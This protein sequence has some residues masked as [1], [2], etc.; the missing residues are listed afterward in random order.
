MRSAV[1]ERKFREGKKEMSP[2]F[3]RSNW[4]WIV[5]IAVG[6][7][8]LCLLH[9]SRVSRAR[10]DMEGRLAEKDRIAQDLL[11]TML[12]N[13]QGLI[14]KIHAV[15]KQMAPEEPTRQALE[16]T[17]DRVDEVLAESSNQLR[18]LLGTDSHSDL[19]ADVSVLRKKLH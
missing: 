3:Y 9:L 7:G 8:G 10:A 19:P 14:L 13:V 18:S 12:Q 11:H 1:T 2:D 17:L 5:G 16:E 6:L 15:V 4:F